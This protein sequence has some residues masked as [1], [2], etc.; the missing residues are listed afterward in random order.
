MLFNVLEL[1]IFVWVFF[2]FLFFIGYCVYFIIFYKDDGCM[3]LIFSEE[4][5]YIKFFYNWLIFSFFV[6]RDK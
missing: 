3:Y 1:K 6:V 4:N 5:M 2:E